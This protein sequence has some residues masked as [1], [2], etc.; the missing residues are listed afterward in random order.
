MGDCQDIVHKMLTVIATMLTRNGR[1]KVFHR[2]Y[3]METSAKI[4]SGGKLHFSIVF[5]CF[6]VAFCIHR[7][8]LS[9]QSKL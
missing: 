9:L 1:Q 8:C 7:V 5:H 2:K 6:I 4:V 3:E